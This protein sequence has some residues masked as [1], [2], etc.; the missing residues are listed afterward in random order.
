MKETTYKKTSEWAAS[1][2]LQRFFSKYPNSNSVTKDEIFTAWDRIGKEFEGKNE[3]WLSNKLVGI[4]SHNLAKP[5]YSY[6]PYRKLERLEL[7]IKGKRVLGRV[8][9]PG[10]AGQE[11][12]APHISHPTQPTIMSY[13]DLV[14]SVA[15]FQRNNQ[16]YEVIFEVKLKGVDMTK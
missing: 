4:Y 9:N 11:N 12:T 16:E 3:G 6:H 5:I 13:P 15:E 14:K 2:T 7:T 10:V 8:D 1:R